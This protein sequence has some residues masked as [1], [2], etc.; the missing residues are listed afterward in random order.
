MRMERDD[1]RADLAIQQSSGGTEPLFAL[2]VDKGLK[3][4]AYELR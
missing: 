4:K 3:R 1:G 2:R